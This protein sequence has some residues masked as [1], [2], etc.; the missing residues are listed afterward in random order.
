M[1]CS[2]LALHSAFN[3]PP[4]PAFSLGLEWQPS[5]SHMYECAADSG[6][7][8]W[9]SEFFIVNS[10]VQITCIWCQ[11][12]SQPYQQ[13]RW[14]WT[15]PNVCGELKIV[16]W[17]ALHE[18]SSS[19]NVGPCLQ[20]QD[21]SLAT[22]SAACVLCLCVCGCVRVCVCPHACARMLKIGQFWEIIDVCPDFANSCT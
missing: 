4:T 21:Y 18:S 19:G 17:C 9:H 20:L 15:T 10:S 7:Q 2:K 1:A 3:S 5:T 14:K 16:L 22:R 8:F 13:W 11:L 6:L 12:L